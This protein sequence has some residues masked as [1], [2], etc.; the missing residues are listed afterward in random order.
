MTSH[1]QANLLHV[2]QDSE[3]TRLG[4][5]RTVRVDARVLA[6][7]N[8]NLEEH[9]ASA[10]FREDVYFRLNVI[11]LDIPPL[12]ERREDIPTLC[13]YSLCQYRDR[14]KRSIDRIVPSLTDSVVR[15]D[16]P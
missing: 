14:Y 15:D 10:K 7:T 4:G 13:N 9:V 3:Y 5:K 11:R 2:R 16:C 6:S 8:V 1:L 12:R